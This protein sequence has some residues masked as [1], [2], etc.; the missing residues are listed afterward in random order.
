MIDQDD[1]QIPLTL[2]TLELRDRFFA[3]YPKRFSLLAIPRCSY[4][5]LLAL[6][7]GISPGGLGVLYEMP[8]IKFKVS[9][10]QGKFVTCYISILS[11][12]KRF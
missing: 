1:H 12:Y 10:M 11:L 6:H 3:N 8:R 4:G 5:L 7:L 9:H 2:I